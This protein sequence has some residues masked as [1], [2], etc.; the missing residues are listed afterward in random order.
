MLTS[1]TV[2]LLG[3]LGVAAYQ[4]RQREGIRVVNLERRA[5]KRY[6][7]QLTVMVNLDLSTRQDVRAY[8]CIARVFAWKVLYLTTRQMQYG[9]VR[10]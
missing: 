9:S 5:A 1:V 10:H 7:D 4:H 8:R 3:L 2:K 6:L